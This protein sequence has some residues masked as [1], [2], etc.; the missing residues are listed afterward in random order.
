MPPK[1]MILAGEASGDLHG[2]KLVSAL[3]DKCPDCKIFGIGGDHMQKAGMEIFYHVDQLAYIG[4]TEVVLHYFF[5]R[6]VFH[7]LLK[8]V[9][10]LKP[11]ILVLVDYPGFNLRFAA[12]AKNYGVKTFYF[13][14]PQV[15]A[16]GQGRAKKM[17][18]FIDRMGVIFDFEVSFFENAGIK[19]DFVGHPLLDGLKTQK[20]REEFYNHFGLDPQKPIL[21]LLPGSRPQEIENLLPVML[22]TGSAIQREHPELQIAISKAPTISSHLLNKTVNAK[23]NARIVENATYELMKYATAA[24]VASGTATLETALF[25]T[26]FVITYRVSPLSYFLGKKLIKI[27]NIGLV[28]VVSGQKVVPEFIQDA[29]SV[30]NLKPVVEGLLFDQ[31]ARQQ[32]IEKLQTVRKKLGSPGAPVRTANIILG[33]IQVNE[34]N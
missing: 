8:K 28:N 34:K 7:D 27:E 25:Q 32:Q 6:R 16:W 33:M 1:I 20:S 10:S 29:V 5:F 18:K 31:N 22:E 17:A 4:F 21:A 14:A 19:A 13:I 3:K 26:P 24:I 15:W 9:Q 23:T 30:D 2:G 11:D 12:K